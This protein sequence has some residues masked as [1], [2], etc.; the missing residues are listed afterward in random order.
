MQGPA[1][2]NFCSLRLAE[3]LTVRAWEVRDEDE[4]VPGSFRVQD[5]KERGETD[6]WCTGDER[7][8]TGA[9]G[10]RSVVATSSRSVVSHC[11]ARRELKSRQKIQPSTTTL[12]R[13]DPRERRRG[14]IAEVMKS[15]GRESAE[16]S[17]ENI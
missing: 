11:A 13:E 8:A 6:V 12:Y 5:W 10:G 9:E 14:G 3:D 4:A 15:G 7:G 2:N 16:G 17:E 1:P